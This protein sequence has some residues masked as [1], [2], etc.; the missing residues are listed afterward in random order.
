MQTV[1]CKW[2][3]ECVVLDIP[4]SAETAYALYSQLDQH[5]RWSPWLYAVTYDRDQGSSTWALRVLGLRVSWESVNTVEEPPTEISWKS[6]TGL[7]NRGRVVFSDVAPD[8]CTMTLTLS[9]DIPRAI[10]AVLKL[11]AAEALVKRTILRDLKRFSTV[12]T[13]VDCIDFEPEGDDDLDAAAQ[14]ARAPNGNADVT[15]E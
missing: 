12:L 5:P 8:R 14:T 11:Q 13:G 2:V 1:V 10:A 3:D 4:A 7:Q 9:Y 6:V 15:L